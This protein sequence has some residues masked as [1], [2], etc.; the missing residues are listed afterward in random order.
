MPSR[1]ASPVRSIVLIAARVHARF[2]QCAT[3]GKRPFGSRKPMTPSPSEPIATEVV[4]NAACSGSPSVESVALVQA[5]FEQCATCRGSTEK[6]AYEMRPSPSAPIAT[7]GYSWQVEQVSIVDFVE[8]VQAR[9]EQCATSSARPPS[10]VISP[11]PS[12]PIATAPT[13]KPEASIVEDV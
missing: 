4:S 9:S 8:A 2:S 13:R 12:A 1:K 7:D 6:L 5:V 10:Y 11:S 3:F